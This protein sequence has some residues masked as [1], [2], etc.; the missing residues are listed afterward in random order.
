VGNYHH[1]TGF[2]EHVACRHPRSHKLL[3]PLRLLRLVSLRLSDA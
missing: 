3:L 2:A 1:L